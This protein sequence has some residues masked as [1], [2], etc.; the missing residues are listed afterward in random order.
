[1]VTLTYQNGSSIPRI[2]LN[3]DMPINMLQKLGFTD[4]ELSQI[5][6]ETFDQRYLPIK[7]R[8]FSFN[9]TSNVYHG[10]LHKY[11]N[12]KF[13]VFTDMVENSMLDLIVVST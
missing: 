6:L 4:E 2:L 9:I 5:D 3:E 11:Q 7:N 8:Y 12:A 1:M 10:V 13:A